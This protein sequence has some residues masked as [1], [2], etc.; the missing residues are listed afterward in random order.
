MVVSA[1]ITSLVRIRRVV[2]KRRDG[3]AENDCAN[4]QDQK[5][6]NLR[7]ETFHRKKLFIRALYTLD[8]K[9]DVKITF[10]IHSTAIGAPPQQEGI[11]IATGKNARL[12]FGRKSYAK[13]L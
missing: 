10:P 1:F 13:P 5:S 6:E 8:V 9:I 7:E 4:G 3:A 11:A 12:A 2:S